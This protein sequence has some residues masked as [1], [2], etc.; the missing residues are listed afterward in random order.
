VKEMMINQIWTFITED[1]GNIIAQTWVS[2][3]DEHCQVKGTENIDPE[4]EELAIERW[5]RKKRK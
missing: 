1:K 2:N 5:E 4:V 3:L